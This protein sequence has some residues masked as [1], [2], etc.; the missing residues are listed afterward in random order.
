MTL[1]EVVTEVAERLSASVVLVDR[2]FSLMAYST[3]SPG[4]DR[5]RV[6]SILTRSCPPEARAWYESFGIADTARPVI[7]PEN[8]DIEASSRICLPARYAGAAYGYLFV[9]PDENS[10]VSDGDLTAAMSL[11][12][13]PARNSH[14]PPGVVTI[15]RSPSQTSSKATERLSPVRLLASKT[16]GSFRTVAR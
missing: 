7:T 9:L 11:A 4:V 1:D 16:P 2:A 8:P 5:D 13:Q 12:G 15:W 10:A 6:Q 14:T 3:Q